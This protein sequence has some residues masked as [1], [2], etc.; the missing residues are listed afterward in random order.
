VRIIIGLLFGIAG[1]S[2]SYAQAFDLQKTFQA[3]VDASAAAGFSYTK[4]ILSANADEG[5]GNQLTKKYGVSKIA[6]KSVMRLNKGEAEQPK[7]FSPEV[8]YAVEYAVE[9]AALKEYFTLQVK[10][11]TLTGIIKPDCEGKTNLHAQKFVRIGKVLRY[12]S[13]SIVRNSWL[14]IT[15]I[16]TEVFFNENGYYQR[17]N[18]NMHTE[19]RWVGFST[20]ARIEGVGQYGGL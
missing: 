13:C 9:D 2:R 3:Q 14:Y 7:E 15:R 16:D 10:G 11:D 20:S 8:S 6:G 1:I 19:I 4:A 5:G 18:L 12:V 17:H